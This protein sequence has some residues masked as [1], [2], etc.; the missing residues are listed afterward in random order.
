MEIRYP[1]YYKDFSCLA[2]ACPDSCCHEWEVD[3]DPDAA[4][5]YRHLPGELGDRLREV[6]RDGEDGWATWP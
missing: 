6:L 5:Y 2:G 3:V 4:D 1:A